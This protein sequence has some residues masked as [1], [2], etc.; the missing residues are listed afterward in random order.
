MLLLLMDQAAEQV[1]RSAALQDVR[2][3]FGL[4]LT[5]G[6]MGDLDIV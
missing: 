3:R 4:G 5:S 1:P 2:C 6:Q